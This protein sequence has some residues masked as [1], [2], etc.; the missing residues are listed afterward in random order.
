MACYE[1]PD[2]PSPFQTLV[3]DKPIKS[4]A[5]FAGFYKGPTGVGPSPRVVSL[6]RFR[7]LAQ[8]L[9]RTPQQSSFS[10]CYDD[11][12]VFETGNG[13]GLLTSAF[14]KCMQDKNH[15]VTYGEMMAEMKKFFVRTNEERDPEDRF[16]VPP[17]PMLSSSYPMDLASMVEI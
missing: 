15:E 14:I 10:A 16:G 1:N 7:L 9:T 2:V 4:R 11:Q 12:A 5:T 6:D 17:F 13:D 3:Y 8:V